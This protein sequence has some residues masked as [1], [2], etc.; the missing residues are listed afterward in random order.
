MAEST[1]NLQ[2]DPRIL[3]AITHNPMRPIDALCELVDNGI[4]AFTDA[5]KSN[6]SIDSPTIMISIPKASDV[7]KGGGSISILDNGPGLTVAK[8]TNALKAGYTSH[9]RLDNLGVFGMGFKIATGKLGRH[10]VFRT[11]VT[12]ENEMTEVTIDLEDMVKAHSYDVPKRRLPKDPPDFRG[13][14][15]QI[16]EWWPAGTQ[17]YGFVTKL[18]RLGINNIREELGRRY[19]SILRNSKLR[20]FVNDLQCE[21]FEHC[22]WADHRAVKHRELGQIPAVVRFDEVV[23]TEIRCS[24]CEKIV[25]AEGCPDCGSGISMRTEEERIRGWVGIQRFDDSNEYGIDL[26]RQGRVIRKLEKDAFFSW[27]DARG[28]QIRDYPIDNMY[29]RIVGEVHLDNV[30]TDFM[31]QDFQR[32][33][34]EWARAMVYLRGES[35]LQP[36]VAVE[37]GEPANDTPIFRLYQGYRRVRDV[38]TR[39]MYMGYWEPGQDQ[40]KRI[41]REI[42]RDYYSRF[43][44]KEPGYYDDTEWWKL[45]EE[46][47][48]KPP[49]DVKVCPDCS[50]QCLSKA[51]TC[52]NCGYI[53]LSKTCV[54]RECGSKMAVSAVVCPVC[55][56]SQEILPQDRWPCAF[57]SRMNAPSAQRCINCGHERGEPN[58]FSLEFLMAHS[59]KNDELSVPAFSIPL[60]GGAASDSFKVDVYSLVSGI[61]LEREGMAIPAVTIKEDGLKLFIDT[62]HPMFSEY[63][64]HPESIISIE[65]AKYI[66]DTNARYMT[67]EQAHLWALPSLCWQIS[68]KYWKER[69]SI[70]PDNTRKRAEEFFDRLREKLPDLVKEKSKEVFDSMTPAQQ[71]E[72]VHSIVQNGHDARELSNLVQN[73]AFL[74]FLDNRSVAMMIEQFPSSFFDGKLW[75][76]AYDDLPIDD[77]KSVLQIRTL[78]LSRYRNFLEDIL[79]FLETKQKDIAYTVRADQTLHLLTRR[80]V[81]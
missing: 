63:Q 79:S 35:C 21:P 42:E 58:P 61:S 50:F 57:C 11:A 7:E 41:S 20:I 52:L 37:A 78:I 30:P 72:L 53:F 67:G 64:Q 75:D 12:P 80:L 5:K 17:N 48:T 43:L 1:I 81:G 38:G 3:V 28:R 33:S 23:H 70:D 45:V 60:P 74:S 55:G 56:A 6:I 54:K 29:G 36:K 16:S 24:K 73:G 4:D 8:T 44:N 34:P 59:N 31:K 18:A 14:F 15:I 25:S 47:D 13:T 40:A 22:V 77:S 66:Q 65:I 26:I 62:I 69:L 49:E 71:G 39:D 68:R 32:T 10:T 2:P 9:N 27:T 46:A 51:E 76:D 19:Y